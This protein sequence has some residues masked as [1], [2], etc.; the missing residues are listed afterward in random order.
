MKYKILIP[1]ILLTGCATSQP[2]IDTK[3]AD[4]S[5]YYTDLQEC[6]EYA[7][8]ASEEVGGGVL[9]GGAV[10]A[11]L[12]A[13]AGAFSG[14]AGRGAAIGAALMSVQGLAH[15][16]GRQQKTQVVNNCLVGRGYKVLR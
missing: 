9:A 14:N 5:H 1:V 16:A 7:P 13:I 6:R 3:G 15:G 8:S 10:G 11:T 12:G 4:M 2:V